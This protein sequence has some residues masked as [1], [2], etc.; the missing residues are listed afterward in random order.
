M[1]C[2]VRSDNSPFTE[3]TPNLELPWACW[4]L[5]VARVF[6]VFIPA[7][8][9]SVRGMTSRASANFWMAYCSSPVCFLPCSA[10][11]LLSSISVAPPPG[12]VLASLH[13]A[14]KVFT[15]S[16]IARSMSSMRWSVAPLRMMVATLPTLLS[17]WISMTWLPPISTCSTLWAW[18]SCSFPGTMNLGMAW[19]PV[20]RQILRSSNL[21]GILIAIMRYLS[22]KCMAISPMDCPLTTTLTP[23]SA[24]PLMIS[25]SSFS[26]LLW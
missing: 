3:S 13:R 19:A 26:S 14:L 6:V 16:S 9:A 8:S 15:P 5:S 18:P 21:D 25:S 22:M 12:T 10:S 20:A 23:R 2:C 24:M 4:A 7:F 1:C 11:L 17:C